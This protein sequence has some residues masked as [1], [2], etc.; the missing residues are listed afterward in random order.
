MALM[1]A[2][3]ISFAAYAWAA[4]EGSRIEKNQEAP[5]EVTKFKA[6]VNGMRDVDVLVHVDISNGLTEEDAEL[7]AEATFFEVMGENVLHRMDSLI[8]SDTQ[9]N[10][11]Y[12]WG[13]DEN[14]MGHVFCL[15]ADLTTLQI[16]VTHCL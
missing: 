9:I 8:F 1:V 13:N 4:Y 10:A 12:A 2:I 14:D 3:A 5:S 11:H 6:V 7:I 15:N 16:T